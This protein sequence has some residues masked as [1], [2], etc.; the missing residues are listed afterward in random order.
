MQWEQARD[1][2]GDPYW[3]VGERRTGM[4]GLGPLYACTHRTLIV[5]EG[6]WSE[7]GRDVG[8]HDARSEEAPVPPWTL[9]ELRV[10]E[11]GFGDP[12]D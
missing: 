2:A 12:P 3:F 11:V 5:V 7:L 1:D 9:D 8:T 4:V 6:G 10:A